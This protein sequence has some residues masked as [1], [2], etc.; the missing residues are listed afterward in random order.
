[1]QVVVA[2]AV[3]THRDVA[4]CVPASYNSIVFNQSNACM[5]GLVSGCMDKLLAPEGFQDS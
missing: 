3:C 4:V 1:M 5:Y 2:A